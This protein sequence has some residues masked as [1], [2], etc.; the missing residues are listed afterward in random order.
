MGIYV[1]EALGRAAT[2][3]AALTVRATPDD[4][5]IDWAALPA[6]SLKGL[7]A[8]AGDLPLAEEVHR[9]E[10]AL[11]ALI[12]IPEAH[13][14]DAAAAVVDRLREVQRAL[15]GQAGPEVVRDV[16]L[17]QIASEASTEL[18]RIADRHGVRVGVDLVSPPG[19][20]VPRRI[21]GVLLDALGHI[22]RNAVT[23]GTPRGG[24][25]RMVFES[26]P[27]SIIVIVS[28]RGATDRSGAERPPDLDSGRGVG[29]RA[30]HGRLMAIGG[31]LTVASGAW[32]GTS[33][34][35]RMPV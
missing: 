16:A 30:A 7:A 32:G 26:T 14:A 31:D 17:E 29:L 11:G 28:D 2:I 4:A 22:V 27:E 24:T 20:R 13:R 35:I 5:A 12:E 21:A 3:I 8:Q 6:H 33:V 9:I 10:T 1:D 15:E 25:V 34:T 18:R 23:H 19:A